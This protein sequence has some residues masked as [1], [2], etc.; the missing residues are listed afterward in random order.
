MPK[1]LQGK[2][3]IL[4]P[5]SVEDAGW[6]VASRDE[7]VFRWTT[8]RRDLTLAETEEAIQQVNTNPDVRSFAIVDR[9]TQALMGNIALTVEEDSPGTAEIM[10][11]LAPSARGRGIATRAV[12]CLCRWAFQALGVNRITLNTRYGNLPSQRAARRAG[13]ISFLKI[14]TARY[15]EDT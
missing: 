9:V 1:T 14:V 5:W 3:F 12:A 7:E 15:G 4:R 13:F 6:Y 10:Y 8:E 2:D 11:W